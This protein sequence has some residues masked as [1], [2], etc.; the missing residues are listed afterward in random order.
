LVSLDSIKI[1]KSGAWISESVDGV[2]NIGFILQIYEEGVLNGINENNNSGHESLR[3]KLKNVDLLVERSER[4]DSKST[5][6]MK[7]YDE[8]I[9]YFI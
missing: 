9:N 8:V 4:Y 1:D 6:N 5:D 2:R 7:Q 3:F